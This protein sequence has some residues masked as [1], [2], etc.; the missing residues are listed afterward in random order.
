MAIPPFDPDFWRSRL[1]EAGLRVTGARVDILRILHGAPLP[2]TAGE[3]FAAIEALGPADRVTVYR[4]L[5][6]LVESGIAHRVDPGDR[7]W[8]YGLV[9]GEHHHHAHF[10][11][12]ACGELRCL[13]DAMITVSMKGREKPDRFKITQQ[14][15][16][17]HGTC[18]TCLDDEPA[19]RAAPAAPAKAA[20][21]PRT[22]PSSPGAK[23]A[24]A[25]GAKPAAR[26]TTG[27]RG[28]R[29]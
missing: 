23:P 25:A 15:V 5:N 27:K 4:T 22:R 19:V 12:D 20:P 11:C 10:V 29:A 16:Y 24:R 2:L 26:R 21:A 7:V 18:E 8:R 9:A 13:S 28:R 14:D 17:L 6:S 1:R 3:A